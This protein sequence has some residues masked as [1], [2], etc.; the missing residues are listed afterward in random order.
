[1]RKDNRRNNA[2]RPVKIATDWIKLAKGS[3]LIEMGDTKV[4]CT[5]SIDEK[6]PNFLLGTGQ[7]W[8]TAEYG[9]LPASTLQRRENSRTRVDGRSQEIQ[10]LI[11]RSLRAVADLTKLGPRTVWIDCDVLQAD[12][13]TRT[14]SITGAYIALEL[15]LRH[16]VQDGLIESVPLNDT[17]AA[18][19]VGMVNGVSLLDLDYS[20][21]SVAEVDMNVVMTGRGKF[22]EIQGSAEKATFDGDILK[23]LLALAEKGIQELTKI[24]K[25]ILKETL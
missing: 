14:A 8:I 20:E 16:L 3:V 2:L 17:V 21:D 23:K 25:N 15:A 9:M 11:G 19:S 22:V 24:Q 4:L 10:R 6:I 18:V 1:M 7:G 5:A 13:G 12:G